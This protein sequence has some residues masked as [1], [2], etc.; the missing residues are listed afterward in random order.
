MNKTLVQLAHG[1]RQLE[2][3]LLQAD[4]ELTPELETSLEETTQS[5]VSKV[6]ACAYVL[7]QL[8]ADG[9]Y[10]RKKARALGQVAKTFENMAARLRDRVK[11]AMGELDVK[12]LT[13]D[14][15]RFC[16]S[17][18]GKKLV[19]ANEQDIPAEYWQETVV[20]EINHDLVK[21]ALENGIEIPGARLEDIVRLSIK[22]NKPKELKRGS[23][24][25]DIQ[26]DTEGNGR[27]RGDRE[28]SQERGAGVQV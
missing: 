18:G 11:Y 21:L 16:R 24:K 17:L 10:Y 1:Y 5:L 19:I 9:D 26:T 8:D 6:D 13:G 3:T 14:D 27:H 4:G 28:G 15:S 23:D 20:R 25:T 2:E 22:V 12:E 7:E